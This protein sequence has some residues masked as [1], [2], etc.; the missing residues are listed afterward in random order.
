MKKKL[1]LFLLFIAFVA[2]LSA[3]DP[4]AER[5]KSFQEQFHT[6]IGIA[7]SPSLSFGM[8]NKAFETYFSNSIIINTEFTLDDFKF[9]VLNIGTI[10]TFPYM[11]QLKNGNDIINNA[12]Q[13]KT[14]DG[15]I[16]VSLAPTFTLLKNDVLTLKIAPGI[17]YSIEYITT[18]SS[19]KTINN[20]GAD[21]DVLAR[22]LGNDYINILI[23]IKQSV[24]IY[25]F[26]TLQT[27]TEKTKNNNFDISYEVLPY[28][29]INLHL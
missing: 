9:F 3:L 5:K 21:V 27:K 4:V 15:L 29:G 25:S 18:P 8:N 20:V 19:I 6:N 2:R 16:G 26:G 13:G 28:I 12:T 22:L 1:I 23:G 7:Y 24:N 11:K 14:Q 10:G 17:K